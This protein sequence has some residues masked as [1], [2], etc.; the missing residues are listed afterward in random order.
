M[1]AAEIVG[2]V[3]PIFCQFSPPE[4]RAWRSKL[5]LTEMLFK[6]SHSSYNRKS[7]KRES[8]FC[9]VCWLILH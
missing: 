1:S 6:Y 9:F 2:I 5:M 4:T 3:D 8:F 7:F